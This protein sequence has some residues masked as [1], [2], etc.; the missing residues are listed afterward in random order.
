MKKR[1]F[2]CFVSFAFIIS[3]K[4]Q[5]DADYYENSFVV[6]GNDVND[7]GYII[8]ESDVFKLENGSKKVFI[9]LELDK[10]LML[11]SIVVDVFSGK[12]YKNVVDTYYFDIPSLDYTYTYFPLTFTKHG[13][14]AIDIYNQDN[15]YINTGHFTIVN[16]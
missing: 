15:L 6:I 5:V 16:R 12:D 8:D 13:K 11:K 14:Y 9:I 4:S 3:V 7:E 2:L 10:P 1:F